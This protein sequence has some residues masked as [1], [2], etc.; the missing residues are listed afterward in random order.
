MSRHE[1]FHVADDLDRDHA[2]QVLPG[3]LPDT[4]RLVRRHVQLEDLPGY[5]SVSVGGLQPMDSDILKLVNM[6]LSIYGAVL[7]LGLGLGWVTTLT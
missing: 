7:L 5:I 6:A 2:D 4:A 1:A 3:L